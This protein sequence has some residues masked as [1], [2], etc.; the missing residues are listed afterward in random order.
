MNGDGVV[1]M[2]G[3]VG[4]YGGLCVCLCGSDG[5]CVRGEEVGLCVYGREIDFSVGVCVFVCA[6]RSDMF[7]N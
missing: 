7:A 6:S 1:C 5:D 3:V 4:V 2:D